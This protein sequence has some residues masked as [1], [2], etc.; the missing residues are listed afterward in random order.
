MNI[1]TAN[2]S[3]LKVNGSIFH[4]IRVSY[5]RWRER[6]SDKIYS[7]FKSKCCLI[8][9][10]SL[11]SKLPT[12]KWKTSKDLILTSQDNFA[13]FVTIGVSF[14]I[15]FITSTSS[16][17]KLKTHSFFDIIVPSWIVSTTWTTFF[18]RYTNIYKIKEHYK[19]ERRKELLNL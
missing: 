16:I 10:F 1:F 11:N 9:Y 5:C 8:I 7:M 19:F 6:G 15:V 2:K 13:H 3:F 18:W 17:N 4:C 12:F 14:K